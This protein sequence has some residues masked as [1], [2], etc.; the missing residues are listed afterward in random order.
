MAMANSH[1]ILRLLKMQCRQTCV[2][3]FTEHK[4]AFNKVY[5]IAIGESIS[6]NKLLEHLMDITGK[7]ISP[8][9]KEER[10]GDVKNSLA[11]IS[12]AQTF[13][14]YNPLVKVKE[15]LSVTVPWFQKT[16]C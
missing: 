5:N 13:L 9:Y 10:A 11:D 12:V 3:F 7:K 4:D 6:L 8:V 1:A 14:G 2:H 15:G 16:F